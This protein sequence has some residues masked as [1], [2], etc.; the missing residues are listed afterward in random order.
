[1]GCG[2]WDCVGPRGTVWDRVGPC[3]TAWDRVGPHGTVWDRVGMVGPHGYGGLV[4]PCGTPDGSP[5][6]A[7]RPRPRARRGSWDWEGLST[8]QWYSSRPF[9][10]ESIEVKANA[11]RPIAWGL[12]GVWPKPAPLRTATGASRVLLRTV[13]D[14]VGPCGTV[15][16]WWDRMGMVGPYGMG[17]CRNA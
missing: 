2:A 13:W 7:A 10:T 16:V 9:L 5:L 12:G 15:W 3:G 17:A 11:D 1:M 14:R 6:P 4:G 8:L